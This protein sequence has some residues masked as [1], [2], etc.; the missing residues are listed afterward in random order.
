[1]KTNVYIDS[2]NL[3]YGSLKGT[4]FKWCDLLKLTELHL[5]DNVIHRIR[6]FTAK[7]R[8]TAT[9]PQKPVRQQTYIRALETIGC[10]SVHYGT[11]LES[12][13]KMPLVYPIP[14]GSNVAILTPP[15]TGSVRV[16]VRKMEEKGSDMNIACHMLMDAH[17]DD[18]DAA[19]LISNDSDLA[20]PITI[21]RRVF[22]KPVVVLHPCGRVGSR[23]SVTLERVASK[24]LLIDDSMLPL[25]QFPAAIADKSGRTISKPTTW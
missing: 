13:A 8:G 21:V 25:S 1:M 24:S 11:Y 19:V 7:V 16:D 12:V 20:E 18:F 3:Y 4:R 15:P 10:L 14:A 6:F 22:K 23:K 9:D 5:P 2:F 17:N